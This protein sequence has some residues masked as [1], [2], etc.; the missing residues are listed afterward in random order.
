MTRIAG[1]GDCHIDHKG[2]S[3]RLDDYSQ[4]QFE[5]FCWCVDKAI[6]EFCRVLCL[7]GDVFNTPRVSLETVQ[8]YIRYIKDK[9][10]KAYGVLDIVAVYGQHDLYYHS[11]TS[12]PKTPLNIMEAAGVLTIANEVPI[13]FSKGDK[14]ILVYGASWEQAI[15][16][17]EQ[18]KD[19]TNIL[20]VHTMMVG[21]TKVWE[22]Q[23]NFSAG[24]VFLREYPYDAVFCGD[25]HRQFHYTT[26][27]GK[28][29]VNAGSLMRSRVDQVDHI[30][31]LYVYDCD[32]RTLDRFPIPT[33]PYWE[34]IDMEKNEVV[35]ER[36]DRIE[37]FVASLTGEYDREEVNFR[38]NLENFLNTNDIP[39]SVI[40]I[41][42]KCLENP[43]V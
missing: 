11:M 34:V 21:E 9:Q 32:T 40:E 37:A 41:I 36:D 10:Q 35:K 42:N 2:P 38:K 1:L 24:R 25:N 17:P 26:P 3:S 20:L 5:K 18:N 19:V 4:T 28:A 14:R 30:P 16:I 23:E 31:A 22:G 6:D 7:P 39:E 33:S 27:S 15:P 29:L 8:R 13:S 43:H 12:V